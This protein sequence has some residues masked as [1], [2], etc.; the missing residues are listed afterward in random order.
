MK[1]ELTNEEI[2]VLK[3]SLSSRLIQTKDEGEK[4]VVLELIRKIFAITNT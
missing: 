2:Q 1:V 4:K 3:K